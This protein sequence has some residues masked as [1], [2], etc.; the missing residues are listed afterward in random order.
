M[1]RQLLELVY[2]LKT[3]SWCAHELTDGRG[4]SW[5]AFTT[6]R[7]TDGARKHRWCLTCGRSEWS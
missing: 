4:G 1:T 7:I 3:G 5:S 6:W 2:R